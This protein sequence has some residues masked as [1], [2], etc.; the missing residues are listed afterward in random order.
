MNSTNTAKTQQPR[1]SRKQRVHEL[2]REQGSEEAFTFGRRLQ[3]QPST[4]HSWFGTW[5]REAAKTKAAKV[6]ARTA[7]QKANV[8]TAPVE[9]PA[10]PASAAADV[11]LEVQPS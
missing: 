7:K 11:P 6:R 5:R 10:E 8:E 1:P 4:L 2:Y 3:L 9:A